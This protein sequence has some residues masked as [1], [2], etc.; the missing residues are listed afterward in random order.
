MITNGKWAGYYK[1]DNKRIQ[2]LK[3]IEHTNFEIDIT[4]IHNNLFKG[5]VEDDQKTGGTPGIGE[6]SGEINGDEITFI[7]Q[8][9]IRALLTPDG[10]RRTF[11]KPHPKIFYWGR[12]SE[13]GK[14]AAGK[15]KINCGVSFVGLLM[16][17]TKTTTGTWTMNLVE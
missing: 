9:P 6:I 15:W 7:K 12:L 2:E 3:G 14:S 1:Y 16:V 4:S 17:I 5:S 8:M 10:G 13:D 11:N